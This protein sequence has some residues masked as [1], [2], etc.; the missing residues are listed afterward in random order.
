MVQDTFGVT[1]FEKRQTRGRTVL[2]CEE[3][4]IMGGGVCPSIPSHLIT[5]RQTQY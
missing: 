3:Q 2:N 1:T 4:W 5:H